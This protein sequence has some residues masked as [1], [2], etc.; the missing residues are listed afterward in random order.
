MVENLAG[1][2]EEP[3]YEINIKAG[4]IGSWSLTN[5]YLYAETG[6]GD[7]KIITALMGA[8]INSLI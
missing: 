8:N 7:N 2:E 3:N 6:E 4:K 5:D 1:P